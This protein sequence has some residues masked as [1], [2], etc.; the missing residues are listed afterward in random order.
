MRA[1]GNASA[2]A[3][4]P[5]IAAMPVADLVAFLEQFD[6][7]RRAQFIADLLAAGADEGKL[8]EATRDLAVYEDLRR[9]RAFRITLWLL[10]IAAG[11]VSAFHGYR[12]TGR[13]APTIGWF[14]AGTIV[15]P[16]TLAVAAAQGF[17]KPKRR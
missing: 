16:M 7:Q 12:R 13:V 3:L 17:A 14:V 6:K 5:K 4:A 15:P 1:L 8:A 11:T 2:Q 10:G 9:R